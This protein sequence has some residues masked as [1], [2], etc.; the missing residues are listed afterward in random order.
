MVLKLLPSTALLAFPSGSDPENPETFLLQTDLTAGPPLSETPE[1]LIFESTVQ[2][3]TPTWEEQGEFWSPVKGGDYQ[4]QF[5]VQTEVSP[6]P[7][8]QIH[9]ELYQGEMALAEH[10]LD[11]PESEGPEEYEIE[12][13]NVPLQAGL[14]GLWVQASLIPATTIPNPEEEES[15]GQKY[16]PLWIVLGLLALVP[17]GYGLSRIGKKKDPQRSLGQ[18]DFS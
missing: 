17:I 12:W 16:L 9:F 5:L 11:V 18:L 10:N 4:V 3:D 1:T 15:L 14:G 7:G 2:G 13:N 6:A 8:A